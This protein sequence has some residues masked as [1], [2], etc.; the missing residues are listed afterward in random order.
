MREQLHQDSQL[1]A[2]ADKSHHQRDLLA[3]TSRQKCIRKN[4][5]HT[6]P[7]NVIMELLITAEQN[8]SFGLMCNCNNP[9]CMG[10]FLHEDLEEHQTFEFQWAHLVFELMAR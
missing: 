4:N 9:T 8:G 2:S 3:P 7:T 1:S 6:L 10:V 5:D